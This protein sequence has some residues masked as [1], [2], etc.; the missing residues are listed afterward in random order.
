MHDENQ[1]GS[2]LRPNLERRFKDGES[3]TSFTLEGGNSKRD[4]TSA[5]DVAS[6]IIKLAWSDAQGLVN[7]ASGTPQTVAEFAQSLTAKRLNVVPTGE[8]NN[9]FAD[10]TRLEELINAADSQH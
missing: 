2:F 4:F 1:T 9:L 10:T 8:T 3:K 5:K 6:L 7:V